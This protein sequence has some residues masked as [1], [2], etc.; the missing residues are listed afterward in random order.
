MLTFPDRENK[1]EQLRAHWEA[2][3]T[4]PDNMVGKREKPTPHH[5]VNG[6]VQHNA[7]SIFRRKL[8]HGLALISLTQRKGVSGRRPSSNASLAVRAPST[9]DSTTTILNRDALLSPQTNSTSVN[10]LSDPPDSS[11]D[12]VG[13]NASHQTPRQL[14]RSRTFSHIPRLAK[15]DGDVGP[16]AELDEP[17]KVPLDIA[18][19]DPSP[20]VP[21]R[22]PTPSPPE[23]K[24]RV[25]NPRQYLP[26]NAPL[27]TRSAKKRQ[28]LTTV[29]NNSPSKAAIRSRTTPNLLKANNNGH[30]ASYM[31]PRRPGLKRPFASSTSQ[32]P[33]LS[34]NVPTNKPVTQ[35]LSQIQDKAVKRESLSVS[36]ATSNRRSLGPDAS[37]A[38]SRRSSLAATSISAK[39]LSSVLK[40]AP[41]ISSHVPV[42][43]QEGTS[44]A[45]SPRPS[46]V[47]P[48]VQTRLLSQN[49]S[50]T[51]TSLNVD[52]EEPLL[53]PPRLS[54]DND[55]QRKTLGTP[56]GLGG[57]WRSSKV[58]AAASHQVR[59]LP[60]SSTFHHFGRRWEAPPPV[61]TIP[62][63]YKSPS[64]SNLI[65]PDLQKYTSSSL[66]N[67]HHCFPTSSGM[68]EPSSRSLLSKIASAQKSS[69]V[70]SLKSM[71]TSVSVT[72]SENQE[73][74]NEVPETPYDANAHEILK[75]RTC[76]DPF[77]SKPPSITSSNITAL[78]PIRAKLRPKSKGASTS[79]AP[80]KKPTGDLPAQRQWSIS[81]CFYSDSADNS[82]HVQVKDYMPPLYWAGRFQSRFDQWRTAAMVASLNSNAQH[83]NEGLLEQ[84][85]L[86]NENQAI[87]LI[88]MQLRDLCASSQAADSLHVR[89]TLPICNV[90]QTPGKSA[91]NLDRSSSTDTGKIT[92]CLT[93][94]TIYHHHYVSPR[95]RLLKD[96]LD[97]PYGS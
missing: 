85:S 31:A 17:T 82:I 57:A 86:E 73:R 55:T 38:Q 50:P 68:F 37:L 11:Q 19:T 35:R 66:S 87:I 53:A 15:T 95:R 6:D 4:G 13:P 36:S 28:S 3:E 81:E 21:S 22:I 25:S 32:K 51:P 29:V 79:E 23:S 59:R 42:K 72:A 54:V 41:T 75:Q 1:F 96:P 9:T 70:E 14:P 65:Q 34:E 77:R 12:S 71:S 43:G 58:F 10:T 74:V 24:R 94:N 78:P 83:G 97:E 5:A 90:C 39:R 8:S 44:R 52:L 2:A 7:G 33:A 27:E 30:V 49:N 45:D 16:V 18:R 62:L 40:Q 67:L 91:N 92:S 56:N 80:L 26:L 89:L 88:F 48:I 61:P 69:E 60:R 20:S 47:A 46:E 76:D 93:P 64:A 84:C 63:Q